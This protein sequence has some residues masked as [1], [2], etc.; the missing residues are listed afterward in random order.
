MRLAGG[1]DRG[2][3]LLRGLLVQLHDAVCRA[4]VLGRLLQHLLLRAGADLRRAA[5]HNVTARQYLLHLRPPGANAEPHSG[6]DMARACA[7]VSSTPCASLA[8]CRASSIR[9]SRSDART[10]WPH[11]QWITVGM[12]F[13]LLLG[14]GS[15]R[16]RYDPA[17]DAPLV[18]GWQKL[19]VMATRIFI[20]GRVEIAAA[21]AVPAA[22]RFP[23]RQGRRAFV[24]LVCERGRPVPRDELAEAV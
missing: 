11:G 5:G 12:A 21:E 8:C 14:V 6:R 1:A 2:A 10:M 17:V 4:G 7:L 24:Y 9:L 22:G 16:P 15:L 19:G 3:H 13:P 23:G 20:P 18:I